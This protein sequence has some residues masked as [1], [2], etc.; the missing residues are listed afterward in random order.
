MQTIIIQY[1]LNS[2][3]QT[4]VA[5]DEFKRIGL[6][7][8]QLRVQQQKL[9]RMYNIIN[10]YDPHYLCSQITV[11]HTQHNYNTRACVRS[12]KVPRVNNVGRSSFFF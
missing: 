1:L 9:H 8:V 4:H 7:S 12:C 6:L 3:P 10:G 5:S 11:V 2:Y